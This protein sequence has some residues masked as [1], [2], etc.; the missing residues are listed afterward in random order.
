MQLQRAL[1]LGFFDGVH[2]A[3]RR[4]L[5]LAR[6]QGDALG[7]PAA[8][9]TFDRQPASFIHHTQEELICT[10]DERIRLLKEEA[11]MDEVLVLP[12][13]TDMMNT[14]PERF[15]ADMLFGAL[16]A[17][18]ICAGFDY[19]FGK[20]GAGDAQLLQSLCKTRGIGCDI[21]GEYRLS[22][23]KISSSAIR[24]YIAQGDIQ[25][26][27]KLLGRPFSFSSTVRH[28][29]ALGR[30][31]GFPTMNIPLPA[32][33]VRP[34]PGVYICRT[35]LRGNWHAAV[36]N[37]SEARLCEAYMLGHNEDAY[38]EAVAVELMEFV[39]PMRKFS[40]L[41]ELKT[42]VD[43]D[44]KTARSWFMIRYKSIF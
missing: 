28:G 7:I 3:H 23:E 33:I 1:A 39:R 42:Q 31:L 30:P 37:I 18:Y 27:Q 36:C 34:A 26:A 17:R 29:K 32:H 12:F 24:A 35:R 25:D 43:F 6:A 10:L 16:G 20:N 22:G 2:P 14:L 11:R 38:G 5:A 15:A 9:V 40:S 21:A 41:E 44:K 8:A 4:V 13:D 19:R